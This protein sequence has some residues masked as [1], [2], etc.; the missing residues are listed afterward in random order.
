MTYPYRSLATKLHPP[1]ISIA[2]KLASTLILK[3]SSLGTLQ[4][5]AQEEYLMTLFMVTQ[6]F[7]I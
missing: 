3:R 6:P 2:E 7:I 5:I 1:D 4:I